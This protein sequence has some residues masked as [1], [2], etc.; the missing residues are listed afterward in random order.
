M[1]IGVMRFTDTEALAETWANE[2]PAIPITRRNA[3]V[4]I[5]SAF[6]ITILIFKDII[7]LLQKQTMQMAAFVFEVIY[8]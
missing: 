1:V 5:L 4:S 2:L 7:S 6:F 3:R 8:F